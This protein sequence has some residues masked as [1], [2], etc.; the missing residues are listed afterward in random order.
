MG[1]WLLLCLPGEID[2]FFSF[3]SFLAGSKSWNC[4]QTSGARH[5]TKRRLG[6]CANYG[7]RIYDEEPFAE[8]ANHKTAAN[9]GSA[10]CA[11]VTPVM[12]TWPLLK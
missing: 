5:H 3:L 12:Y 2:F 8:A 7:E 11:Y 9:A 4:Y 6:A 1:Q 10:C